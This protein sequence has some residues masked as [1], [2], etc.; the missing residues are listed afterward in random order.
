VLA[1]EAG[2]RVRPI[3]RVTLSLASFYNDYS[4]LRSLDAISPTSFVIGNGFK[5][6]TWGFELSGTYQITDWWRLRGGYTYLN[7]ILWS[8]KATVSPSVREGND[9]EN[10]VLLQSIMNLPAHFQL[11][12]SAATLI[13]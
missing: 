5:G 11:D 8:H 6:Q 9:P 12:S 10:Q 1:Y 13:H 2:Y 3:D 7:K 4:D